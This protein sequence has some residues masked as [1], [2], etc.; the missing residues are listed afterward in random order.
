M[1][2]RPNYPWHIDLPRGRFPIHVFKTRDRQYV[3]A[4]KYGDGYFSTDLTSR[5]LPQKSIKQISGSELVIRQSAGDVLHVYSSEVEAVASLLQ[6]IHRFMHGVD[7]DESTRAWRKHIVTQAFGATEDREKPQ[8]SY[9]PSFRRTVEASRSNLRQ[10]PI[11]FRNNDEVMRY[12]EKVA[13]AYRAAPVFDEK[14]AW[15][16]RLLADHIS[17]MFKRIQRG[18]QGVEVVFV[19]GQ[20]YADAEQLKREVAATGKL[21][22]STDYNEHPIFTPEQNLEF[23]AVHDHIV[24]IGRDVD[25]SMRGE[26]AAYNAHARLAPPDA[27]PALFTE[28]V[29]QAAPSA[30]YGVFEEQKI[31]LLPFDYYNVGIEVAGPRPNRLTPNQRDQLDLLVTEDVARR[32]KLG[33]SRP[34]R[35][36]P[37]QRGQLDLLVTEDVARRSKLGRKRSNA[38]PE[39]RDERLAVLREARANAPGGKQKRRK[40]GDHEHLLAQIQ[41]TSQ[42]LVEAEMFR[43]DREI[44][45]LSR[46]LDSLVEQAEQEG[47]R[48]QAEWAMRH[49][50]HTGVVDTPAASEY[51][52]LPSAYNPIFAAQDAEE[53]RLR[54]GASTRGAARANRLTSNQREQ[55]TALVDEDKSQ[56]SRLGRKRANPTGSHFGPTNTDAELLKALTSARKHLGHRSGPF[57]D[58]VPQKTQDAAMEELLRIEAEAQDRGVRK[59]P[60]A[61]ERAALEALLAEHGDRATKRGPANAKK[62]VTAKKRTKKKP[63]KKSGT[64]S[65]RPATV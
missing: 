35:L 11:L 57:H 49:G 15:R 36:T 56:R 47:L 26:I 10:N 28:I 14:E 60:T 45:R 37:N 19:P 8:M 21:Y 53:Q 29:G 48:D 33:R 42:L 1:Q 63:A 27:M 52:D 13:D 25:F 41:M 65:R 44:E 24:H 31:A 3:A 12:A 58:D 62:P 61:R 20:P 54:A 43:P 7:D 5:Y 46:M 64:Q 9:E 59:N 39:G 23:R 38:T 32:S 2:T 55:L 6:S 17:K 40:R 18:Q 16:W 4:V 22:I 51:E 34:N 30:L 50:R